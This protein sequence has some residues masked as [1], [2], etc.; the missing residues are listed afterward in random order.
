MFK[1]R[2]NKVRKVLEIGI[3]TGASLRMWR[4][5]FPRAMIYGVDIDPKTL[6]NEDRIRTFLC[7]QSKESDL[8]GLLKE[9]GADIDLIIDDGSHNFDDQV[10]SCLTLMPLVSRGITYVIEDTR[11]E[12]IKELRKY[13]VEEKRRRKMSYGDDRLI[14]V[15]Y[16]RG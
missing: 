7:D 1:D 13:D 2:K 14:I 9:T 12:I 3:G 10:F 16:K 6:F 4:D 15:K 5:F 11:R 8:L